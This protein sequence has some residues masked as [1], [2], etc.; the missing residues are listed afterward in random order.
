MEPI[1]LDGEVSR[2]V[3]L[4]RGVLLMGLRNGVEALWRCVEG[5]CFLLPSPSELTGTPDALFAWGDGFCLGIDSSGLWCHDLQSSFFPVTFDTGTAE[6]NALGPHD[7]W[8]IIDGLSLSGGTWLVAIETPREGFLARMSPGEP[9]RLLARGL[10]WAEGEVL[11][12]HADG[13][14]YGLEAEGP[15]RM[16]LEEE[17]FSVP[18]MVY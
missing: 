6:P 9:A 10:V 2:I 7:A 11:V 3:G 16:A 18:G 15:F 13:M 12:R 1:P 4:S 5:D 8:S 17:R 14:I